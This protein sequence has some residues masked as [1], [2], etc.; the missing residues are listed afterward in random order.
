MTDRE[1]DD[2]YPVLPTRESRSPNIV[3]IYADDLGYGDVGCFGSTDVQTPAL[4][5]LCSTGVRLPNWYSNSPVCSPS[6]ASLLTG[7]Y[8]S[9]AGVDK[10]L[11]GSRTTTGLPAQVTLAQLLK[12]RGYATGIFGKWHLG[13]DPA[14]GPIEFGFDTHFGFRAG[15]V[16]YYS[17]IFYWGDIN[18]IHDLWHDTDEVWANGDYLTT[19]LG[20]KAVEFIEQ[21]ADAPFFCYVPFNAPHY[22]MHAPQHYMDQFN[23]L[24]PSRQVMAAMVKAMDDSVQNIL[25]ALDRLGLRDNTI[26]FMSSDNGP[27]NENRNWLGG[28]EIAYPGG[29]TG[30]LRGHKGSLFEGG[31]RVPAIISW[32]GVLPAGEDNESVGL[33]MDIVPTLLEAVDGEPL[34][35]GGQVVCDG[36]SLLSHLR[37]G[38][39]AP[40][41]AIFWE[42]TGQVSVRRGTWKA[43]R[44]VAEDL[45]SDVA[46]ESALYD[47]SA[48]PAESCNLVAEHPDV[49]DRLDRE[50]ETWQAMLAA[51]RRNGVHHPPA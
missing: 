33:M 47:L 34:P 9:H 29:S 25:D 41:R 49:F 40:E 8:P 22:P 26:V 28:E 20:E 12:D 48:D 30:G 44:N 38:S 17:H 7:K 51:W 45:G 21:N 43:L 27:S 5:A 31:V 35:E 14:S 23:H 10:I 24:D 37:V 2:A 6:R 19:L 39:A 16:D 3:V 32:P 4:D 15:C 13:A 1:R 50:L 46:E 42:Y 11:G 18:P 36:V